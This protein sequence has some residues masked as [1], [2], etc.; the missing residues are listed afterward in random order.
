MTTSIY[1][2]KGPWTGTLRVFAGEEKPR[3]KGRSKRGWT[4]PTPKQLARQAAA[5]AEADRKAAKEAARVLNEAR[6]AEW[7]KQQEAG[8]GESAAA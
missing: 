4:E 6:H 2:T 5:K 8:N 3:V 1:V 7:L